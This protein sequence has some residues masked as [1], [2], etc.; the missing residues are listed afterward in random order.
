VLVA[1]GSRPFL[2][3]LFWTAIADFRPRSFRSDDDEREWSHYAKYSEAYLYVGRLVRGLR[4]LLRAHPDLQVVVRPHPK[5][6]PEAWTAVLGDDERFIVTKHGTSGA[7]MRRAAALI[8]NGSTTAA[9]A[10]LM[11]LP[12]ISFQPHG[13]RH[14]RFTNRVGQVAGDEAELVRLVGEALGQRGT[15]E[16]TV[17]KPARD[18]LT[19]RLVLDGEGLAADRIVDVWDRLDH[20]SLHRTNNLR[21]AHTLSRMHRRAGAVRTRLRR[22]TGQ[23]ALA[24]QT[25]GFDDRP[26]FPAVAADELSALVDGLRRS[27]GRFETVAVDRIDGRLFEITRR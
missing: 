6:P 15:R 16:G 17:T 21:Q 19:E 8:H 12:V 18:V 23:R 10:A 20:P 13:E 2:P 7:W 4:L 22:L 1:P 11:G 5:S 27:L 26:K 3:N 25:P 14:D 9:E 24:G